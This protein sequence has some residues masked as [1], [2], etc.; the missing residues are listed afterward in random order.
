MSNCCCEV[1][2]ANAGEDQVLEN[3]VTTTQL[4]GNKPLVGCGKWTFVQGSGTIVKPKKYN[5]VVRDLALGENILQW[6]ISHDC[7]NC[8]CSEASEDLVTINVSCI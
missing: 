3:C 2:V 5:T 6:R 8:P 7:K 4:D 1:T